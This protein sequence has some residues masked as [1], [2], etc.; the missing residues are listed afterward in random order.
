MLGGF[1]STNNEDRGSDVKESDEVDVT[2]FVLV[3]FASE[4]LVGRGA[5]S[6]SK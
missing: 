6:K 2:P 5:G 4:R 3:Y 1:P